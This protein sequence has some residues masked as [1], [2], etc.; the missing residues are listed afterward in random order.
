MRGM[1]TSIRI[2][3]GSKAL[4]FSTTSI[5][6]CASPTTLM[7]SFDLRM[8]ASFSRT[9]RWSSAISTLIFSI[10]C[11]LLIHQ[12]D[13]D[14]NRRAA[15]F[16]RLDSSVTA[17]KPGPLDDGANAEVVP[18]LGITQHG[19]HVE[20]DARVTDRDSQVFERNI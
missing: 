1:L 5:P 3:S 17:D 14:H 10:A 9:T 8:A 18:F 19:F 11:R 6:S 7:S 13:I 15:S 4:V 2:T 16:L 12:R 20:P